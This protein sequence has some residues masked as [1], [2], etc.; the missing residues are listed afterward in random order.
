MTT[1]LDNIEL[2]LFPAFDNCSVVIQENILGLRKYTLGYLKVK[3][4]NICNLFPDGSTNVYDDK[5]NAA[6]CSPY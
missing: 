4:H 6:K 1:F 2:M 3:G 5:A